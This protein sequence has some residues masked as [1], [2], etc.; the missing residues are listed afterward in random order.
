MASLIKGI[1]VTLYEATQDGV[2]AFNAP[3]YKET[4]VEVKNVL[5]SPVSAESVTEG[6]QLYGKRAI[7]ELCIPKGDTH[8]WEDRKVRFFGRDFQTFGIPE[9][10]IEAN[11][12]MDWNKKVQVAR[13]E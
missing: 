8:N 1:T 6:I 2:D 9:E 4:P 12:P 5:V 10:Y 11:L 7:Y 13:Y 3:I